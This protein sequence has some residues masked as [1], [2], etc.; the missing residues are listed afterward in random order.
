MQSSLEKGL[1]SYGD[2]ILL[3]FEEVAQSDMNRGLHSRT[4]DTENL[5]QVGLGFLGTMG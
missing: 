3:L 1:I 4:T 5:E 2:V